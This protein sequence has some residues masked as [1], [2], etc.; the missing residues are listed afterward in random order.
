MR[1]RVYSNGL[2]TVD[3]LLALVLTVIVTVFLTL[4]IVDYHERKAYRSQH[5]CKLVSEELTGKQVYC[6]KACYR[7]EIRDTYQ[8]DNGPLYHLR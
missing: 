5:R 6:G 2:T 3:L 4:S 8:C 7:A 1:V